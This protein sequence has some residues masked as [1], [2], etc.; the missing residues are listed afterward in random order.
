MATIF[1]TKRLSILILLV[2]L[3]Y[4]FLVISSFA[5]NLDDFKS[6]VYEGVN[7]ADNQSSMVAN[8][9]YFL[10]L[11]PAN[12][13]TSFPDSLVNK[14]IN[15]SIR[16]KFSSTIAL[17]SDNLP[18]P[19]KWYKA[20]LNMIELLLLINYIIIPI[21][22]TRFMNLI[23]R[24]LFFENENIGLLRLLGIELL[25]VYFGNVLLNYMDYKINISI[26]S[27]SDYKI[28]MGYTDG[29]WLLFGIVVLLIAEILSKALAL[30][31]EQ[32]LTI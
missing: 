13:F 30:K 31:E 12:G 18:T 1:K 4:A 32:E 28:V 5:D 11:R 27:F 20:F 16:V 8:R 29:I 19:A 15:K 10:N 7:S 25:I 24:N 22:F 21:H 26:F 23:D 6:G 2:G 3:A 9:L 14:E 17:A